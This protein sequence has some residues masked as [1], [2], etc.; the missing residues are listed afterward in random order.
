MRYRSV[1]ED[2]QSVIYSSSFSFH[3]ERIEFSEIDE[4]R[5]STSYYLLEKTADNKIKLTIDYYIR[6][7]IA[8]Q[9]LFKLNGKKKME[10]FFLK[11]LQNLAGLVKEIKLPQ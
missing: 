9:I 1:M 7:N 2:G 10:D 8:S 6:K 11:S 3:P 4:N 5:K